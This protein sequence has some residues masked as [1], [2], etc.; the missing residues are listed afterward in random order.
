VNINGDVVKVLEALDLPLPGGD[1]DTLRTI[2]QSWDDMATAIDGQLKQLDSAVGFVDSN[3]W[4]GDARNAFNQHWQTQSEAVQTGV[5]NFHEVAKTLRTYA[6][7]IDEVN[8]ELVGICEQIAIATA[9]GAILTV[10]TAGLSDI[11]SA[12]ADTAEALRITSLIARFGGLAE[13]VGTFIDRAGEI[14]SDLIE[15]L[16]ALLES[17]KERRGG[18]FAVNLAS[19]FV[20]D[21]AANFGSQALSGQHITVGADLENGA[22]D[23][24]GTVVAQGPLSKIS[25]LGS[26]EKK[27]LLAGLANV[28]GGIFQS[29]AGGLMNASGDTA[30]ADPFTGAGLAADLANLEDA[31]ADGLGGASAAH[32]GVARNGQ[33]FTIT[34][35]LG[36]LTA[37]SEQ[38]ATDL[39]Q[40]LATLDG[41]DGAIPSAS[42]N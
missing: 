36:S 37:N 18:K 25:G 40:K 39:K 12:V 20:A 16:K 8:E 14:V 28:G 10:V 31:A 27:P 23:A 3:S 17:L 7:N 32:D 30:F 38:A 29:E 24:F 34:D 21:S 5:A 35:T 6:G 9:A 41:R 4:S 26:A 11:A 33:I 42:G 15:R 19:N 13:R 22:L 1:G 2:A